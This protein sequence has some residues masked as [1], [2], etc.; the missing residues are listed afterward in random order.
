MKI[1]FLFVSLLTGIAAWS[2]Q[3]V[4]ITATEKKAL[5]D[6]IKKRMERYYVFPEKAKE[7]GQYLTKRLGSKAYDAISDYNAFL[8]TLATDINQVHH[9]PH[10][11][12][13]FDPGYVQELKQRKSKP[14]P[15]PEKLEEE[16]A[17][18]RKNNYG[19]ARVEILPGNI[20]YMSLIEFDKV[21]D[22]SRTIVAA[23]FEFIAY[24][25]AVIIDLRSNNGGEPEMVQE[26]L[27][28]FF[29][30]PVLTGSTYDREAGKTV[31]NY[32]LAKVKGKKI[33]AKKLYILT[34]QNTFSAPEALAYFM[35]NAK[36]AVIV[37]E[38][39][40]GA[41][42]GTKGFIVNDQVVMQIP[43][44]RGIDPVTKSDWEGVGVQPDVVIKADKA[45]AKAQQ[46]IMEDALVTVKDPGDKFAL[47]W[48]LVSV[49]A[50]LAPATLTDAVKKEYVGVYGTTRKIFLEGGELIFQRGNG[51]K[52]K[53]FALSEDTFEVE[54]VDNYRL[55]FVRN[56][57]G[58]VDRMVGSNNYN[59]RSEYLREVNTN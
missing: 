55:R 29:D 6:S 1:I 18:Y 17:F 39:T 59:V 35:K 2:Q 28:Y 52:R 31:D 30:K 44:M 23:A 25:D 47:E 19:F 16:K 32:S 46:I 7:I 49:K 37:G 27:S 9:D 42:H 13:G 38:P 48:G 33:P 36:R 26:V 22:E 3:T 50:Q 51:P 11:R 14:R 43:F 12:M 41:A 8:D 10:L 53:L 58:K 5:V 21:N 57:E 56:S 20:G 54:G 34:S 4:P 24:A 45:L 40:A 15:T